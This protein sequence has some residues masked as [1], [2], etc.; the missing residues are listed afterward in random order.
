MK[1]C[2]ALATLVVMIVGQLSAQSTSLAITDWNAWE[3][4][5]ETEI[6][7]RKTLV[8]VYTNWCSLCKKMEAEAFTDSVIQALITDQFTI[9]GLDAENKEPLNFKGETYE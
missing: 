5:P 9:V 8:Y 2:F 4:K 7:G 6:Q 1:K 3:T